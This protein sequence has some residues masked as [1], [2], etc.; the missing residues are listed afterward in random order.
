MILSSDLALKTPS[1]Q[2]Y[3]DAYRV[4]YYYFIFMVVAEDPTQ[5]FTHPTS[6]LYLSSGEAFIHLFDKVKPTTL[7]KLASIDMEV[8]EGAMLL[9]AS[10][11]WCPISPRGRA[12]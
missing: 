11:S 12:D 3:K 8:S 6:E 2:T 9:S 1:S 5:G 10:L 4:R 7:S